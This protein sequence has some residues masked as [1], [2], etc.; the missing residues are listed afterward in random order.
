MIARAI[1]KNNHEK[2][3]CPRTRVFVTRAAAGQGIRHKS[4]SLNG[5]ST[6]SVS[7]MLLQFRNEPRGFARQR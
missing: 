4:S 7:A 2:F 5:K 1:Q 3:R 6:G